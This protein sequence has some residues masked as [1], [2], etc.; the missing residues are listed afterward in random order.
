MTKILVVEDMQ[1]INDLVCDHLQ[2]MG[3]DTVG[4]ENGEVAIEKLKEKDAGFSLIVLDIIM[5]EKDGFDVLQYLKKNEVIVPVLAISG[6]GRTISGEVA[7]QAVADKVTQT[8]KK[9][10]SKGELKAAVENI[11]KPAP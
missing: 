8:L 4:A 2:E 10:F 11:L 9:P 1:D 3:Y 6:G 7:L 5:P